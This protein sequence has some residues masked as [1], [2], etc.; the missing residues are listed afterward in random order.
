MAT[1]SRRPSASTSASD[2]R[3]ASVMRS[4]S[5]SRGSC[6]RPARSRSSSQPS[7]RRRSPSQRSRRLRSPSRHSLSRF[8]L[9]LRSRAQASRVTRTASCVSITSNS[10]QANCTSPAASGRSS[11][12]AHCDSITCPGRGQQLRTRKLAHRNR[13]V[14]L[15]RQPR[16]RGA[17][18]PSAA[19]L[20][21]AAATEPGRCVRRLRRP[22]LPASRPAS[23]RL[24]LIGRTRLQCR[25]WMCCC[26]APESIAERVT[27]MRMRRI[28]MV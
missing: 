6:A 10:L 3:G 23:I 19:S 5:A 15:H 12:C 24:H 11:P 20:F 4:S 18:V 17:E 28:G 8:S 16:H 22:L 7:H 9:D 26:H 13:H 27:R 25:Q 1:R 2:W 14:E 21:P